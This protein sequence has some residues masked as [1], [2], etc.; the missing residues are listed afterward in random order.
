MKKW[1]FLSSAGLELVFYAAASALLFSTV[2]GA[3]L[4]PAPLLY[5]YR[6]QGFKNVIFSFCFALLI[7]GIL[8]RS[9][10]LSF[11]YF[12]M[13]GGMILCL[14][15]LTQKQYQVSHIVLKTSLCLGSLLISIF[16][17]YYQFDL[18]S[19]T[20]NIVQYIE[21]SHTLF[22]SQAG[23]SEFLAKQPLIKKIFES[24]H[25]FTN[26]L[27]KHI[28]GYGINF[29]L[30][31]VALNTLLLRKW[32]PELFSKNENLLSWQAPFIILW[33]LIGCLG[34]IVIGLEPAL[35]FA[36]NILRIITFLYFIQGLAVIAFIFQKKKLRPF[37]QALLL[38]FMS[39]ITFP[40]P[41]T[42]TKD[43]F[44]HVVLN[45][46]MIIGF[47]D[48]WFQFRNPLPTSKTT[49]KRSYT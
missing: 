27:L 41:V 40:I 24:P 23:F 42:Q 28:P 35:I 11:I 25:L 10:N 20:L 4:S 29:I 37:A 15:I 18:E 34:I 2:I 21:Q 45:I 44:Y 3:V 8:N 33:G 48:V 43:L 46:P 1:S 47:L 39:L 26:D 49:S 7:L 17:I 6:K 32:K 13:T 16:L 14:L 9:L 22:Q 12:L 30:L 19:V 31:F 38:F 5:L 36:V